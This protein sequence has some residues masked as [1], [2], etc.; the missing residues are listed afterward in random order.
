MPDRFS[1][2]QKGLYRGGRPSPEEL[3]MLKDLWGIKKIV[4][5]D[6]ESGKA[7]R[8]VCKELGLDHVLW[9]LGDGRDPKVSALKKRVVPQLLMGGPTYVHCFHGKDRTG[10]TIAMF[11]VMTGWP[12]GDALSEAWKFGMGKGLSPDVKKSYYEA[13]KLFANEIE[14]DRNSAMDVVSLTRQQNQ[15]GPE[16]TGY[17]NMGKPHGER[18]GVPP[19]ADIEFSYLSRTATARIYCK[20]KSSNILKPKTFWWGSPEAA[21]NNPTDEDGELYSASLV[22][23][24]KVERFDEPTSQRLMHKILTREIDVAA[25][26]GNQYL[27]LFPGSLVDI[28]EEED[29]NDM[30]MPDVGTRDNSTD[31]THAYP[32]SG[33]GVGGM[34]DGAA[35]IVQLPFSGQGQV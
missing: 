15:F 27:V 9:G 20:C 25:L 35:G 4:S 13:V 11:R 12:I 8:P 22:S 29:V 31:Y 2:V 33:S 16:G 1:E 26:R 19:H 24:T 5:L 32:G 17:E 14:Q 7:I 30:F 18:I 10:M 34:P 28:Q 23:D 3:S 21:R 6:E